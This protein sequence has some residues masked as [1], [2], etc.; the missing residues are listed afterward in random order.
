MFDINKDF[1]NNIVPGNYWITK[2][3]EITKYKTSGTLWYTKK[4]LVWYKIIFLSEDLSTRLYID[5]AKNIFEN[6][7]Q[8][9]DKK[10]QKEARLFFF[11]ENELINLNSSNFR[12]FNEF[13]GNIT[14]KN[15]EEK[16]IHLD[17]SKKYYFAS[18]LEFG[19][20]SGY[21]KYIKENY[22][23]KRE[24]N[25]N[26]LENILNEYF[27][28]NPNDNNRDKEYTSL[29]NDYHAALR[30]ER[31]ILF[32][33]GFFHSKSSGA[34]NNEFS[35]LTPIGDIA[36]KSN[37]IELQCLWEHQKLKMI[38]QPPTVEIGKVNLD[39]IIY[40]NFKINYSPYFYL[41][42]WIH[43]NNGIKNEEYQY[44]VSRVNNSIDIKTLLENKELFKDSI[45]QIKM[46]IKLF[47]RT[48]DIKNE[49]FSKELKKYMLGNL[50]NIIL[51]R[52]TNV[53]AFCDKLENGFTLTNKEVLTKIIEVYEK[54]ERYKLKKNFLLFRD[55]EEILRIKYLT[56]NDYSKDFFNNF[57]KIKITY[58]IYNIRPDRIILLSIIGCVSKIIDV[59]Y[60]RNPEII[61][62]LFPN[63][64]KSLGINNKKELRETIE[65]CELVLEKSDLEDGDIIDDD[66]GDIKANYLNDANGDLIKKIK[67]ISNEPNEIFNLDRK[68]KGNLISLIKSLYINMYSNTDNM[69]P[70]EC[71]GETTFTTVYNQ[72]YIE[73]HHLIP[74][75]NL[76]GPDHYLN[77]F[78]LC[79]S[80]HK[81]FH[82]L[83][84]EDKE[85]RYKKIDNNNFY[86]K[87]IENRLIELK[88]EKKL[89]SYQLEFL[90]ADHAITE[91]QYREISIL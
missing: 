23:Y 18:L 37:H 50:N 25:V 90:L 29:I 12:S 14:Y 87:T 86:K 54:I 20:Q 73:F 65:Y 26:N 17:Y 70:C 69:L 57:N 45:E 48:R 3:M 30:N 28:L 5:N 51:D 55:C 40:E 39:G 62:E 38:S 32:Y 27:K 46:K 7:I 31:Q 88:N 85:E 89:T 71:C 1:I 83:R 61:M 24:F 43:D 2:S 10:I 21:K 35:S 42:K 49:D 41:L 9:L 52:G 80:C 77:L 84:Y 36:I 72:P 15:N 63:I 33:Y 67:G 8:S 22:L 81:M 59:D 60:S 34:N 82:F 16:K 58:D 6:Y 13:K 75:K 68:R 76:D 66:L 4:F 47:N 19:G 53:L 11:P 56:N 64:M 78:G 44:I 74:F 79:P 91:E